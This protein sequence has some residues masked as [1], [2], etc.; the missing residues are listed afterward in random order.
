[1]KRKLYDKLLAWKEESQGKTAIL[2]EG[3]RRVGKVILPKNSLK[4]TI[5]LTL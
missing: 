3:A 2:I 4:K 1:M 5:N